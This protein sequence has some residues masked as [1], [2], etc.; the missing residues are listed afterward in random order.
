MD[1]TASDNTSYVDT[2]V[3]AEA[4]RFTASRRETPPD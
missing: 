3:E 4:G 1:D 2:D